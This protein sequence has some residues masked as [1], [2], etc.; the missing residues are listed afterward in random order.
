MFRENPNSMLTVPTLF[1]VGEVYGC[2]TQ[3][4]ASA[5]CGM[6]EGILM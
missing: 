2:T 4:A 1:V 6:R 3:V 5:P